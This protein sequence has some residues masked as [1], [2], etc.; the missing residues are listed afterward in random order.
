[1]EGVHALIIDED[2]KPDWNSPRLVDLKPA[3]VQEFFQDYEPTT[4][5]RSRTACAFHWGIR[6]D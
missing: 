4:V 6:T 3:R 1:M 5:S 2:K